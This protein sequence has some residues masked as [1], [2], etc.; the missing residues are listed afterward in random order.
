MTSAPRAFSLS[1][2]FMKGCGEKGTKQTKQLESSENGMATVSLGPLAEKMPLPGF[3]KQQLHKEGDCVPCRYNTKG[4][5]WYGD[6][7]RYCHFC[8]PEEA[9]KKESRRFYMERLLRKESKLESTGDQ[10]KSVPKAY[11]NYS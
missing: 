8:T 3:V 5:C 9:K 4:G 6:Q 2:A 7:C 10:S 1:L 11:S